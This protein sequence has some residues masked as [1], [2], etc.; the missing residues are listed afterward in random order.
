M[1]WAKKKHILNVV[2]ERIPCDVM[3]R[4][5]HRQK[6]TREYEIKEEEKIYLMGE[7][8]KKPPQSEKKRSNEIKCK[9]TEN[10]DLGSSWLA[11]PSRSISRPHS[12]TLSN[13]AHKSP[14]SRNWNVDAIKKKCFC[15]FPVQHKTRAREG[16]EVSAFLWNNGAYSAHSSP[17][18]PVV[19]AW[20]TDEAQHS[21]PECAISFYKFYIIKATSKRQVCA[22]FKIQMSWKVSSA[23]AAQMI[24]NDISN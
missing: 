14:P 23:A 13:S 20:S 15:F 19:L 12:S 17:W 10:Y 18:S 1:N 22:D 16:R 6:K 3:D 4:S 11:W 2:G 7:W 5:S 8:I 9:R 24:A 21:F